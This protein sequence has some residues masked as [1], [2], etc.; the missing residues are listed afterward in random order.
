MKPAA[1][2]FT[3]PSVYPFNR[4]FIIAFFNPVEPVA[5]LPTYG[6]LARFPVKKPEQTFSSADGLNPV[7][8]GPAAGETG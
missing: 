3:D 6:G 7:S 4:T 1:I 5:C 8:R 2:P